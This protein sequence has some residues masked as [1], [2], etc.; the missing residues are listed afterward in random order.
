VRRAR[1]SELSHLEPNDDLGVCRPAPRVDA[2]WII[3]VGVCTEV[4]RIHPLLG[5]GKELS[6]QFVLGCTA[7]EFASTLRHIARGEIPAS[8]SSP[9]PSASRAWPR[10]SR[11]SAPRTAT[12]R[13]SSS[14]GARLRPGGASAAQRRQSRRRRGR[15]APCP[16]GRGGGRRSSPCADRSGDGRRSHP[17]MGAKPRACA[18]GRSG[19][20]LT[21]NGPARRIRTAPGPGASA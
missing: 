5:I 10:P 8:R 3:M 11:S 9:A 15:T 21:S 19:F 12:P 16:R 4:D 6:V 14:P 2:R 18:R 1:A 13:S 7:E 17:Q 20:G